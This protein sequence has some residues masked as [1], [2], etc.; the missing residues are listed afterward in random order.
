MRAVPVVKAEHRRVES[1]R[2]AQGMSANHSIARINRASRIH[3]RKS[4]CM[5]F[6]NIAKAGPNSLERLGRLAPTADDGGGGFD[7]TESRYDELVGR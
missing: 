4:F 7:V 1:H 5:S 6:S 2:G 3:T